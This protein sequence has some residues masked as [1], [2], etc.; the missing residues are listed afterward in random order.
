[1]LPGAAHFILYLLMLYLAGTKTEKQFFRV[2]KHENERRHR[3]KQLV[4]DTFS[5]LSLHFFRQFSVVH[6]TFSQ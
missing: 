6:S 3:D 2:I 4:Q 1:M 5:S